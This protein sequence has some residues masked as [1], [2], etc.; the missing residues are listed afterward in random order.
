M[1]FALSVLAP[2]LLMALGRILPWRRYMGR[3]LSEL[4]CRAWGVGWIMVCATA[5]TVADAG[6][7]D[8]AMR[9]ARPFWFASLSAGLA[10]VAMWSASALLKLQQWNRAEGRTLRTDFDR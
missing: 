1:Q 7:I 6:T 2:A 8:G 3:N 4:E 5:A 9:I 10:T